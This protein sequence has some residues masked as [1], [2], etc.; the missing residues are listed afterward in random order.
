MFSRKCCFLK[1]TSLILVLFLFGCATT[2][3]TDFLKL[4][5]DSLEKRQL[6]MKQFDTK[7]EELILS[8]CAGVLQDLGFTLDESE[9]KLGL[10]TGSKERDATSGGQLAWAMFAVLVTKSSNALNKIDDVQKIKISIVSRP[11]LDGEKIVVRVTF[12]RLIWNKIGEL[13][14][15]ETLSDSELYVGFFEKLSKAVF[16]E[17]EKI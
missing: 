1:G 11:S 5:A 14:R 3:P 2:M 13:S 16:L 15:V 12:Q 9:T 8:A 7:D 6:Q 4:S 17:A 10:I